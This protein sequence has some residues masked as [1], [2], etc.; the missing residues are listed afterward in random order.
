M[1]QVMLNSLHM[2]LNRNTICSFSVLVSLS[3]VLIFQVCGKVSALCYNIV[4]SILNYIVICRFTRMGKQMQYWNGERKGW[5]V[6]QQDS[7]V[8]LG[9]D[10]YHEKKGSEQL[11][12]VREVYWKRKRII[13]GLLQTIYTYSFQIQRYVSKQ[14]ELF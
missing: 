8:S 2:Q 10:E 7:V 9:E 4:R 14:V 1:G 11:W 13:K 3:L 6:S 5:K 12:A